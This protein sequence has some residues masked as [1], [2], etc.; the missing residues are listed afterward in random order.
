MHANKTRTSSIAEM[1]ILIARH[2]ICLVC[3]L[4]LIFVPSSILAQVELGAFVSGELHGG[5][6][7]QGIE[8]N[9]VT[10]N[11][12][13][14][15]A[16]NP[17][18]PAETTLI[19]SGRLAFSEPGCTDDQ[20]PDREIV[21]TKEVQ[22]SSGTPPPPAPSPPIFEIPPLEELNLGDCSYK[23]LR[24]SRVE[25]WDDKLTT[26]PS[27]GDVLVH[28]TNTD[29]D[30]IF[31]ICG[32]IATDSQRDLYVSV[33]TCADDTADGDACGTLPGT[34]KPFSVVT[35]TPDNQVFTTSTTTVPDVCTGAIHWDIAD[36]RQQHNGGQQIFNL[37]ANEA[38]DFLDQEV[39]WQNEF[40]LQ[41]K[42]P[43]SPTGFSTSDE[44]LHIASADEQDSDVII[45]AYSF[46]VLHQLYG[47]SFPAVTPACASS[48]WG[49][50]SDESCAWIKGAAMFLQ[51]AMQ[52]NPLFE[53]TPALGTP[54]ELKFDLEKPDPPVS[55]QEDEGAVAATLWDL[56]DAPGEAFD[57]GEV[58]DEVEV[59]FLPIWNT[60]FFT[61]PDDICQF[62]ESFTDVNGLQTEFENILLDHLIDCRSIKYVALGDS[63]SSGEGA[64]PRLS[65]YSIQ[66]VNIYNIQCLEKY[67]SLIRRHRVLIQ[68]SSFSH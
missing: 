21:T 1:L 11:I 24:R 4:I 42:F 50:R 45:R 12:V 19:I 48:Q 37:L 64:L 51:S 8:S 3:F 56:F 34:I 5:L 22:C 59:G 52:N 44:I 10:A 68:L 55:S 13:D 63:Y 28:A 57:F 54:A 31:V 16:T 47:K 6:K 61:E 7:P 62:F 58:L 17:F 33:K 65:K 41:V 30:G 46:F 23:P 2:R 20:K 29:S 18:C 67:I 32:N 49:I 66:I 27:A 40:R 36:R 60:I 25:L 26:G 38:F 14:S 39:A 43:D 53:D 15:E 35:T 9:S